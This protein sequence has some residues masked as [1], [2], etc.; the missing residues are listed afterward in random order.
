MATSQRMPTAA[1]SPKRHIIDSP[2]EPAG[3]ANTDF[4]P[5]KSY[6]KLLFSRIVRERISVFKAIEFVVIRYSNNRKLPQ[7]LILK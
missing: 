5:H 2:L 3:P 4:S 7:S 6:F 1:G